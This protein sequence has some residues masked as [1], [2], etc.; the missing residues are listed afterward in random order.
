[1]HKTFSKSAAAPIDKIEQK[2]YNLF[3]KNR[4]IEPRGG[5]NILQYSSNVSSAYWSLY[6]VASI[7]K[8]VNNVIFDFTARA[9]TFDTNLVLYDI[10]N[11]DH[12]YFY[13]IAKSPR[14]NR[15]WNGVYR[16]VTYAWLN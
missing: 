7:S 12:H 1:M 3:G 11:I 13:G 10:T 16:Y 2:K 4:I 5:N 15:V 8:R 14:R 9:K 6:C